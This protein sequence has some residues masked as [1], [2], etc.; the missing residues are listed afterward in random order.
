MKVL[1]TPLALGQVQE[2]VEY[3]KQD[4]PEAAGRW[5]DAVFD[6]RRD[7]PCYDPPEASGRLRR[8][9][10]EENIAVPTATAKEQM[11]E[12]LQSQPDDSS[13]EELLR[14]LAFENMVERGFE[15]ADEGRTISNEEMERRISTWAK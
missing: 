8:L 4:R 3:I 15:D 9:S 5:P 10:R 2:I 11:L 14:E 1:W 7:P 12:I 13:Y 6:P